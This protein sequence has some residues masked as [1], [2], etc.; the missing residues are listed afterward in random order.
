MDSYPI[1]KFV[2]I[3]TAFISI[4]GF[5]IRGIWMIQSSPILQQRWV[6]VAPPINDT[7][8]LLSAIALVFI[9]AQYPGPVAWL[10]AK[11]IALILYIVLGTIALNRGKTKRV[12][13][14]TWVL[15]LL[16]YAYILLVAFNKNIFPI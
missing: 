8:L 11:I 6:K 12:R 9:T 1:I 10:N 14:T 2:H 4:I 7:F 5:F 3:A 16:T 13:I 15:A